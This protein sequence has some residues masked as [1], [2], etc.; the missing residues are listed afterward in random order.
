GGSEALVPPPRAPAPPGLVPPAQE[1]RKPGEGGFTP[2]PPAPPLP[3]FTPAPPQST[4]LPGPAA[5]EQGPS[6]LHQDRND[7]L[8]D[9]MRTRSER[10]RKAAR[11]ADPAVTRA[12][13]D[14]EWRAH[15]L[16]NR[17]AAQRFPDLLKEAA[18]AGWRTDDAGNVAPLPASPE[19]QRKLEGAGIHRPVHDSGHRNWN[20]DVRSGL[21]DIEDELRDD[22]LMPVLMPTL[23]EHARDWSDSKA[24]CEKSC[25]ISFA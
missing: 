1:A 2:A 14:A 6:V 15:H 24:G 17:A 25:S 22:G 4:V 9:G 18:R 8:E 21:S 16:I 10:A 11:E 3:G 23:K 5:E 19:A 13:Q 12:L 20:D 7:G